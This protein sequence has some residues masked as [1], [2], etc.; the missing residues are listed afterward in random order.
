[1][2]DSF[3]NPFSVTRAADFTDE[4]IFQY[5][6]DLTN[7]AGF[8]ELVK[9]RSEMPMLILGSKGSGKT[10]IMR[11]LSFP[12]QQ[13][14]H[15]K[16]VATGIKEEGYLGIYMRCSG[17]NSARFRDKGQSEDVWKTIFAYYMEVWLA[18]MAVE[19]CYVVAKD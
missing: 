1:M 2:D 8:L 16:V 19:T 7:G 15:T 13:L 11:Y 5:W 6:V 17:L 9:P 14:R 12:L 10:H 4:Q 3:D 18:Q